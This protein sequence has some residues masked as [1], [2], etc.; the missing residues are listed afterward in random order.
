VTIA[1]RFEAALV[2]AGEPGLTGPELLPMRLA[3]AIARTLGVDGAGLSMIDAA[4]Q[5]LPLGGSSDEAETAERL[6]FTVGEGPCITAQETRQPVF[7]VEEDLRRK[8]PVFTEMLVGSTSFRAVVALPLQPALAGSG[9]IDLYFR[10]PH[11]VPGLDVFE[12]LAVGELVTS[13]LSDAAVWSVWTP[14][15]G[16]EWLHGPTPQRRAAAWEAM[17]KVSVELEVG[18]PVALALLRAHAYE[19]GRTV[20]DIAGE[21]LSGHLRAADLRPGLETDN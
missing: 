13:A 7:A 10:R 19:A 15:E 18:A 6:Q 17:G 9:A 20:D 21:L 1:G 5:R 16:P 8:W 12:A 14:A 3:R 2:E 4:Q 11:E